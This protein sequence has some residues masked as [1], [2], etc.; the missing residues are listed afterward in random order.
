MNGDGL[1]CL[2]FG[3]EDGNVPNDNNVGRLSMV[4]GLVL[5]GEERL[6][7]AQIVLTFALP[8]FSI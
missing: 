7:L 8:R 6:F 5:N 4:A 1:G 2:D 3:A